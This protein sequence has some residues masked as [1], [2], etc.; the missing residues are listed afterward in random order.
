VAVPVDRV[1][2]GQ[3]AIVNLG[4]LRQQPRRRQDDTAA[5]IGCEVATAT[6]QSKLAHRPA[7]KR[8]PAAVDVAIAGR[9]EIPPD[10]RE[11]LLDRL[12]AYRSDLENRIAFLESGNAQVR[13][14]HE[15]EWVDAT[16]P[17]VT[18]LFRQ[19]GDLGALINDIASGRL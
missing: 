9:V 10:I 16:T 19:M 13:V 7:A 1:E 17:T 3:S 8:L 12:R 4:S 2:R 6:L 14:Q 5:S 18:S 15:G 11:R